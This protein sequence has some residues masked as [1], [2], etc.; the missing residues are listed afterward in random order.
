MTPTVRVHSLYIVAVWQIEAPW[1]DGDVG[2]GIAGTDSAGDWHKISVL[3]SPDF[4]TWSMDGEALPS[5]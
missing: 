1:C 5:C 4:M 2:A 3:W